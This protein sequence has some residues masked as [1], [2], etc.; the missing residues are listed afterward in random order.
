MYLHVYQLDESPTYAVWQEWNRSESLAYTT[1][2]PQSDRQNSCLAW[3]CFI[4]Y[5]N[6]VQSIYVTSSCMRHVS[7]PLPENITEIL[8]NS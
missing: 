6:L 4:P 8:S 1:H 3:S 5:L 7:S 2:S